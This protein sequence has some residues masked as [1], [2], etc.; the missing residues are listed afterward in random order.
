MLLTPEETLCQTRDLWQRCFP[1]DS[2]EFLDL[3]FE[4]RYTHDRN[5]TLR[6]DG[7]VVAA[8]QIFPFKFRF[9]SHPIPVAYVS[10]LCVAPEHRQQGLGAQLLRDAHRKMYD[11]G[12]LLSLLIPADEKLRR[13]YESDRHGAY[14][15]AT[16]RLAVDVTAKAVVPPS[17][18]PDI[19]IEGEEEWG[20][21][22]WTYYNTFGGRH[23]YE[24]KLDQDAFFA[25]IQA[26]DLQGGLV[27]VAR[28]RRRI[29]GFCLA[30]REGKLLKSGKRSVKNFH[31]CIRFLL[32]TDERIMCALQARALALLGVKEL[33]MVGG[34]PARGFQG[35]RPYAMARVV[36]VRKFLA[37]I[38]RIY[39]G[40]QLHVGIENDFDIPEN[41]GYYELME[42]HLSI[43]D[44][45]PDNIITPGG[46]AA[47]FLGAQPVLLPMM[48]DE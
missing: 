40:L 26:H 24:I 34:C 14:W 31:G 11:E 33:M 23:P 4:E 3:Y 8:T 22:L 29:V 30:L 37:F 16:H 17:L 35:A 43:T 28:R 41:N 36:N 13:W 2:P 27:L 48:L 5:L 6:R 19:I 12:R 7:R 38:G 18:S 45:R 42:G 44:R 46:L 10:G 39:P 20:N 32:T 15:T 21:D 25:A 47:L 1:E 9:A